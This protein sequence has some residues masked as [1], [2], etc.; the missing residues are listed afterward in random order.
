MGAAGR[1]LWPS[2]KYLL[3]VLVTIWYIPCFGVGESYL[4]PEN[5]LQGFYLL[6][7]RRLSVIQ[8]WPMHAYSRD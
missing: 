7:K 3:Q 8:S 2:V 5:T 6:V 4:S 1:Q